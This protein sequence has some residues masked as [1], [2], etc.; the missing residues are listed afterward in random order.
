MATSNDG[1]YG[2]GLAAVNYSM[3]HTYTYQYTDFESCDIFNE[4]MSV[5]FTKIDS[6]LFDRLL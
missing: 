6:W 5:L 1:N 2:T 3:V 4:P